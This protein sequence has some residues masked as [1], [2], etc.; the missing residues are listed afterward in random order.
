MRARIR[1]DTVGLT[2]LKA[3]LNRGEH[4]RKAAENAEKTSDKK[5]KPAENAVRAVQYWD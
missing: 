5:R 1:V 2:A 3:L 4:R